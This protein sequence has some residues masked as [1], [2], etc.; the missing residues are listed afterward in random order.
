MRTKAGTALLQAFP[1]ALAAFILTLPTLNADDA[2]FQ[3]NQIARMPTINTLANPQ[4]K[5]LMRVHLDCYLNTGLQCPDLESYFFQDNPFVQSWP[6]AKDADL[7]VTLRAWSTPPDRE[8]YIIT[9]DSKPE[10]PIL[11][12]PPLLI[13]TNF[14][15]QAKMLEIL[16]NLHQYLK[17]WDRIVSYKLNADGSEVVTYRAGDGSTPPPA[18]DPNL[19]WIVTVSAGFS[20]NVGG[21][22]VNLGAYGT[23]GVNYDTPTWLVQT[24]GGGSYTYVS[25]N[26]GQFALSASA[27]KVQGSTLVAR[28]VAQHW[29]VMAIARETYD[30]ISNLQSRAQLH[31]GIEYELIPFLESNDNAFMV[32]YIIG[33]NAE[34]YLAPNINNKMAE[35]LATHALS[36]YYVRHQDLFDVSVAGSITALVNDP[37][38]FGVGGTATARLHVTPAMTIDLAGTV[39]YKRNNVNAPANPDTSNPIYLLIGG[40][41]TIVPLTYSLMLNLTYTWGNQR[42]KQ[43]DMRW[44]FTPFQLPVNF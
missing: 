10:L 3:N 7:T 6:T 19:P 9:F 14:S 11:K 26:I 15:G 24:Q 33:G 34:N 42:L 30:P 4:I 38:K 29:S 22:V 43:R 20:L 27:A 36:L 16:K 28:S 13:R 32:N 17:L 41:N 44:Q 40:A 37:T 25:E 39:G 5:A 35:T 18:A 31:A 21:G 23:A 8:A 12:V 2:I 1:I